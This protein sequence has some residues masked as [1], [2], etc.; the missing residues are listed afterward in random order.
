MKRTVALPPLL[1]TTIFRDALPF[2][3]TMNKNKK[4]IGNL[5]V[6]LRYAKNTTRAYFRRYRRS[7]S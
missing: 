2:L 3:A 6:D 5:D 1:P 7:F 4:R